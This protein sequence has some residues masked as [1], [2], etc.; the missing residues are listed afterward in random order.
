MPSDDIL[1][2]IGRYAT[3]SLSAEE[4]K[5]LFDA[6]LDDQ[7]LFDQLVREQ[8]MK[9]MLEEPGVRDRMI[10]ALEPPKRKTAWIYGVAATAALSIALAVV[11][12]RPAP[13]PQQVATATIPTPTPVVQTETTPPP[14]PVKTAETPRRDL[15]DRESA[16]AQPKPAS[17]ARVPAGT[18]EPSTNTVVAVDQP[19]KDAEKKEST[20]QVQVQASTPV[21]ASAETVQVTTAPLPPQQQFAPKQQGIAGAPRQQQMSAQGRVVL[22]TVGGT[23]DAK[24][25]ALGLHY[26]IEIQGHLSI[27]PAVDGYLFVKS[28]DGTILFGP[29][30]SAAGIIVDLPLPAAAAS[31]VITFSETSTPV[32]TKP[33]VRTD[34]TGTVEGAA[35]LAIQ[36]RINP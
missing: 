21:V 23:V 33:T 18:P 1:D 28:N 36:V 20:Q 8:D 2:L 7:D 4:H 29:K 35:N 9:Q 17:N 6:A 30:L 11:L 19:A 15:V 24:T 22:P 25:A 31:V 13:K 14:A 27:I 5:R 26:S 34:L 32:Q 3:G 12:L 16:R 10:R